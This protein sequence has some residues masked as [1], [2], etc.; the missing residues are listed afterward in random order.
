MYTC[1]YRCTRLTSLELSMLEVASYATMFTVGGL[2]EGIT[3]LQRLQH[4]RLTDC[5]TAPL[6]LGIDQLTQL[7][8][9]E[10]FSGDLLEQSFY[11]YPDLIVAW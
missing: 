9:L 4:L 3:A 6:A 5:V 2:P 1:N 8:S 11:D 10:I 7:T